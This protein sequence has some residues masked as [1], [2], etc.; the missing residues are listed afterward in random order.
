VT[1]SLPF[2][3]E[4]RTTRS[5]DVAERLR[6]FALASVATGSQSCMPWLEERL[7][8]YDEIYVT[9]SGDDV[10]GIILAE[11]RAT[12]HGTLVYLGPS[13]SRRGAYVHGFRR[14]VR[15][16]VAC[17]GPFA[18]AMEIENLSVLRTLRRLLPSF[19]YPS[20]RGVTPE[21]VREKA[22]L[23]LSH[24]DHLVDFDPETMTSAVVAP[25]TRMRAPRYVVGFVPCDGT[26][27]SRRALAG[28][29]ERGVQSFGLAA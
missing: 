11:E 8:R 29:L 21:P 14:A 13:F 1:F 27:A 23:L 16:Q 3:S 7:E 22:R 4:R 9:R 12:A 2:A 26:F 20:A 28:E 17:E 19:A 10:L 18:I 24:V 15:A 25:M 6:I 5:L